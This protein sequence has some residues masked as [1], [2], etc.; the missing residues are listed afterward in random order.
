MRRSPE[1]RLRSIATREGE[2]RATLSVNEREH[3]VTYRAAGFPFDD[4]PDAMFAAAVPIAMRRSSALRADQPVSPRLLAGAS[5][6]QSILAAWDGRLRPVELRADIRDE[7]EPAPGRGVAAFFTGGVDSFYSVLK[8]RAELD[9]L[10]YVHGFDVAL[11]E[12][13]KRD[14]VSRELRSV[15]AELELPLIEVETDLRRTS[16]AHCGWRRIYTGVALASVGLLLATRFRLVLIPATHSYRDLH[17]TGTHPLLDPLWSTEHLEIAYVDAVT[18]VQKLSE[19]SRSD[20]AMRSLRVCFAEGE[21]ELNCGRCNKCLRTMAGLRIVGGLARCRTLPD[22]LPLRRISRVPIRHDDAMTYVRENLAAAEAL[23]TDP[24]LVLAL[25]RLTRR[26]TR[27][28]MRRER[29][30]AARDYQRLVGTTW[31]R[32]RRRARRW[33]RARRT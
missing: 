16:D 4:R 7:G 14:L 1:A 17:P 28:V 29:R 12:H 19:I 13:D 3:T 27:R 32:L 11:D 8:R 21:P 23:G 30:R 18:R 9:A 2:L 5:R 31:L 10:V 33:R 20:L 15:A 25:R 24:R 26:G 6:A 22:E